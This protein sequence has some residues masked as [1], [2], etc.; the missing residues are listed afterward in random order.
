MSPRR[1]VCLKILMGL[2][3]IPCTCAEGLFPG[4]N[5]LF[6]IAL[7]SFEAIIDR[8]PDSVTESDKGR[9]ESYNNVSG[10]DYDS[11]GSYLGSIG[12]EL[13]EYQVKNYSINASITVRDASMHIEY[14]W[15]DQTAII[16]Y[17]SGTRPEEKLESHE[18][19]SSILPSVGGI[20]PSAEFA[21]GKKPEAET[22]EDKGITLLFSD[23]GDEEYQAFSEYLGQVGATTKTTLNEGGVLTADVELYGNVITL[24]YDW[25][26]QTA[27][28]FY[29]DGT[30]PETEKWHIIGDGAPLLPSIDK[31]GSKLPHISRAIE[32]DPDSIEELSDGTYQETYNNF[33]DDDYNSLSRY[34][35]SSGCSVDNYF[36][37]N[38]GTLVIE[39]SNGSGSF[40]FAYDA[41]RHTGKVVYP[42]N[43]RVEEQWSSALKAA[44]T[45]ESTSPE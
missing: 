27:S 22:I 28:I 34:L 10:A 33:T 7:P 14:N 24:T 11:F 19:A 35:S 8:P 4:L 18:K 37:Q 21:I 31:I 16:T 30:S 41:I 6:G 23:F 5:Q 45:A 1:T 39:L 38:D 44:A 36:K 29:P 12:A 13:G 15:E 26:K 3:L 42:A 40:T 2:L 43:S 32:R 17:P 25:N 20:M 9:K